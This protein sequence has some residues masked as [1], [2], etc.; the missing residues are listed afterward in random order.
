MEM[1]IHEHCCKALPFSRISAGLQHATRH[2][3][4]GSTVSSAVKQ[5]TPLAKWPD[6]SPPLTQVARK[7]RAVIQQNVSVLLMKLLFVAWAG[8]SIREGALG[9]AVVREVL[10]EVSLVT[11]H[12]RC[13]QPLSAHEHQEPHSC[14]RVNNGSL[15]LIIKIE[16]F[17]AYWEPNCQICMP[18]NAVDQ[19]IFSQYYEWKRFPNRT[20]LQMWFNIPTRDETI[21]LRNSLYTGSALREGRVSNSGRSWYGCFGFPRKTRDFSTATAT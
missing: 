19:Y 15:K 17:P 4:P 5:A 1:G 9:H 8:Y 3:F 10:G 13:L 7:K 2:F 11:R 14:C 6:T 18:E 16:H 21:D 20:A 12:C